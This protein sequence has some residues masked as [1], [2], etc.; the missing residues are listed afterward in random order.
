MTALLLSGGCVTAE[1]PAIYGVPEPIDFN[2]DEEPTEPARVEI[3]LDECSDG[4]S[5]NA[6][7][8]NLAIAYHYERAH[9]DLTLHSAR[10][11]QFADRL[12]NASFGLVTAPSDPPLTEFAFEEDA[13]VWTSTAPTQARIEVRMSNSVGPLPY[14]LFDPSTYL[15]GAQ[16]TQPEG[17]DGDLHIEHHGP[18]PLVHMLGQG[19]EPPN[20]LVIAPQAL[21]EQAESLG[22]LGLVS[23]LI[24]ED[25]AAASQVHYEV[26][27]T[28]LMARQVAGEQPLGLDL[29]SSD[30]FDD[31][32]GQ[33]IE[34]R[35][36]SMAESPVSDARNRLD[37]LSRINVVGGAFDF[38]AA[39]QWKTSVEP[40]ITI[41]CLP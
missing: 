16:V 28:E 25:S 23:T 18:G 7:A 17:S 39:Y 9:N 11:R 31:G 3:E 36:W 41:N 29:V 19:G 6:I 20:P 35:T 40:T 13:Y 27:T 4:L 8:Q 15:L 14:D 5:D 38:T 21:Q 22:R 24:V 33:E 1:S 26:T 37:G 2:E 32:T 34:Q 10:I 12:S 30:G